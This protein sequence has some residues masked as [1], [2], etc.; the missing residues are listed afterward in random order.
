MRT[1]EFLA[2]VEEDTGRKL[3]SEQR[4]AVTH[5]PGPLWVLAGP[6]SGKTEV[7]VLRCLKLALVDR[8]EPRSIILTTFTEK[9]AR[10]LQERILTRKAAV[11]ARYGSV[12]DIDVSTIRIGTLHSIANDVMREFRYRPYQNTQLLDE[13]SLSFKA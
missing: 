5:G 3:N 2:I 1:E 4:A 13:L 6:G 8:V 7:L 9:A 10:S 12:R 11:E